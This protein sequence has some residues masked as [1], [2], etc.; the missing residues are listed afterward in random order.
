LTAELSLLAYLYKVQMVDDVREA[1]FSSPVHR[2][3]YQVLLQHRQV[4]KHILLSEIE[5]NIRKEKQDVYRAAADA[6]YEEKTSN[7]TKKSVLFMAEELRELSESRTILVKVDEIAERVLQKDLTA[8]KLLGREIAILGKG[9]SKVGGEYLQDYE[10]RAAIVDAKVNNPDNNGVPT[11]IMRFDTKSGGVLYGEFGVVLGQT[12]VGKSVALE[13]FAINAWQASLN[14][15]N[16]YHNVLYVSLEMGKHDLQFRADARLTNILFNKFRVGKDWTKKDSQKWKARID[17]LR[18]DTPSYFHI[19][20][21]P[22][23]CTVEDVEVLCERIQDER[24]KEL[25][26]VIVDYLNILG[27]GPDAKGWQYQADVA[28]GLKGLAADFNGGKGVALWTANQVTDSAEDKKLLSFADMKYSRAIS[29][30]APIVVGLVRT[31]DD[32]LNGTLQFQIV[33]FR[34]VGKMAPIILKPNYDIALLHDENLYTHKTLEN[35]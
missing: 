2:F 7:L 30:V 28:W 3:M 20:Y 16:K 17:Q 33:K 11:G 4:P 9:A 12:S 19:E 35:F 27:A 18:H 8:A 15:A 34:N 22:R 31:K 5:R 14:R 1:D 21:V 29:E 6:L 24:K 26:L 25:D 13:N 32:L 23:G 10:E